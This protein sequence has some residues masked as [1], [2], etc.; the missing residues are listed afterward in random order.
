MVDLQTLIETVETIIKQDGSCC[1]P[2]DCYCHR[3]PARGN[4]NTCVFV[5]LQEDKKLWFE[6]WL[7]LHRKTIVQ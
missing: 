5:S 2:I 7:K 3:C 4:N 6:T 1:K